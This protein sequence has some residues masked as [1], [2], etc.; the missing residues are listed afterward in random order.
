VRG[1]LVPRGK[2]NIPIAPI[3]AV[4]A[5]IHHA[6]DYPV[7]LE[8]SFVF[9]S[10]GDGFVFHAE[11]ITPHRRR[12]I[13]LDAFPRPLRSGQ[14]PHCRDHAMLPTPKTHGNRHAP[15]IERPRTDCAAQDGW[16]NYTHLSKDRIY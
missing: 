2:P 5:A 3:E 16:R 15:R 12:P 1:K 6:P 13:V 11:T 4:G 10:I 14:I 8:I 9:S 7:T